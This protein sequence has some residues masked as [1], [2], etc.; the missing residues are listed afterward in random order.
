[1]PIDPAERRKH[2]M[3]AHP[4]ELVEAGEA[5]VLGQEDEPEGRRVRGAVVRAV[6]LLAQQGQ[7]AAANLVHDLAGLL[8][9]ELV[10]PRSLQGTEQVE[11]PAGEARPDPDRLQ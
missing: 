2:V 4:D 9:V 8:V 3:P 1:M 11:R 6:W 7:L 5:P 10:D